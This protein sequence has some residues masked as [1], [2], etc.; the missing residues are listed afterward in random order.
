MT[1]LAAV[2]CEVDLLR[3]EAESKFYPALLF[4]GEGG[5]EYQCCRSWSYLFDLLIPGSVYSATG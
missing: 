3:H 2:C 1:V 4:Y 5:M